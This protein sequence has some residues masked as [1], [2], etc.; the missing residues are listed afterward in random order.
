MGKMNFL[1]SLTFTSLLHLAIG[2]N[3][4]GLRNP[5]N[6]PLRTTFPVEPC[7]DVLESGATR[8]SLV[9][10]A[11]GEGRRF[12]SPGFDGVS[13]YSPESKCL[14][15]FA[16]ASGA[17]L[18]FTCTKFSVTPMDPVG[19][20]CRGD[21]LRFYDLAVGNSLD[22]TGER[23]CHSTSP[24]FFYNSE[25]Q[26]LFRSN[27]DTAVSTGFDCEVVASTATTTTTTTL[28]PQASDCT[29]IDGPG[30]GKACMP[31]SYGS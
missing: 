9:T 8:G 20:K 5:T 4:P 18:R 17:S 29:T 24:N 23:Y 11:A 21:F 12:V 30:V 22:D 28:G 14:W 16:P 31:F 27:P 1:C 13:A 7:T 25:I 3:F 26:V 10:L 2:I 19:E 15:T 6:R